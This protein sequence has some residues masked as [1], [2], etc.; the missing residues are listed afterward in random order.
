MFFP[1]KPCRANSGPAT[2]PVRVCNSRILA[3][4]GF[5]SPH[6]SRRAIPQR[7]TFTVRKSRGASVDTER[8]EKIRERLR[9]AETAADLGPDCHLQVF[10][11][12]D[13]A[14]AAAELG[15]CRAPTEDS[16]GNHITGVSCEL[17][18][19]A[20]FHTGI[21]RDVYEDFEGDDGY[22]FKIPRQ[23]G[24]G[25]VRVEVKGTIN[26]EDPTR[27]ISRHEVEQ[28]DLFVLCRTRHPEHLVEI[29]G[30]A[31]RI[32]VEYLGQ[33]YSH[34]GYCLRP[35]Y[36]RPLGPGRIG[37]QELKETVNTLYGP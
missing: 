20:A 21:N 12:P 33:A 30:C 24:D 11:H 2:A 37:E 6:M 35:D 1:P 5:R 29:V 8:L 7:E 16:E 27:A 32:E 14:D 31:F 19:G 26:W 18:T 9:P 28:A 25:Q 36:L 34:D 15:R 23:H 3:R 4:G 17:A 10:V 13:I 22:D